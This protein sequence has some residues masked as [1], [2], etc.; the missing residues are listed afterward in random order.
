MR[1]AFDARH[2]QTAS[3]VRGIGRYTRNLLAAFARA[4]PPDVDWTLLRLGNFPRADASSLP[5]H[6]DLN[7]L[8]LRRPELS[9]LALDPLLLSAE[10]AVVRPDLYHSVQLGLPALRR[11]A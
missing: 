3:R 9:M 8:R 5:G 1:V 10:L 11:C 6:R 2:L 4:D 7:T